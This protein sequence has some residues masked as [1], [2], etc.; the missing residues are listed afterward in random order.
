MVSSRREWDPALW[1]TDPGAGRTLQVVVA[2]LSL[3]WWPATCRPF[4]GWV[5]CPQ[6]ETTQGA[7]SLLGPGQ[8]PRRG[9]AGGR[10]AAVKPT[11]RL[12]SRVQPLATWLP[13]HGP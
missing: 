2:Y 13:G 6:L 12:V 7:A 8:V 11:R 4:W 9:D 10:E 5:L 3:N 1:T